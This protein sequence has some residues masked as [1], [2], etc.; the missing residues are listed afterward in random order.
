MHYFDGD[1]VH[2]NDQGHSL[3]GAQT[4]KKMQLSALSI[5]Q[6]ALETIPMTKTWIPVYGDNG[7]PQHNTAGAFLNGW[8]NYYST[9]GQNSDAKTYPR[10]GYYKDNRTRM[11]TV[12]CFVSQQ[13]GVQP[14]TSIIFQLPLGYRPANKQT[15]VGQG[16]SGMTIFE[17]DTHGNVYVIAHASGTQ[18]FSG[19]FLAEQ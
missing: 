17:I 2:Y 5:D 14:V 7:Q 13:G 19:S 10:T 12:Q 1:L 16:G 3:I 15:F 11:V 9:I 6:L 18:G 8:A 4:I